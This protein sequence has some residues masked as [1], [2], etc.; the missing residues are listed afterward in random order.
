MDVRKVNVSLE[1][2]VKRIEWHESRK[3]FFTLGG[4]NPT[5]VKIHENEI[6]RLK[7]ARLVALTQ[8]FVDLSNY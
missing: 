3:V 6:K 4:N 2:L 1:A 5:L 7:R 8:G